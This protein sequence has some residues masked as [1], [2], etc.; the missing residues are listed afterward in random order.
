MEMHIYRQVMIAREE[1]LKALNEGTRSWT[2]MACINIVYDG[3]T[4]L[5][6]N[7]ACHAGLSH[8]GTGSH[9]VVSALMK[10]CNGKELLEEEA[11][12]FLEWLLNESPYSATFITKS[13]EEALYYKAIISSSFHDARLM[14][15]GQVAS[16]RLWEYEEV[17]RSFVDMAKAGVQKDL[18]FYLAHC[19]RGTFDRKG[20]TD[21]NHA[22]RGHVSLEP[23]I[24]GQDGLVNFLHHK[25]VDKKHNYHDNE[26]YRGYDYMYG[27]GSHIQGWIHKH[28]PYQGK[29]VEEKKANPFPM[30]D[31]G[32]GVK[33]TKSASYEDLIQGMVEFQHDI[34]KHIGFEG[35]V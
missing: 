9:A 32:G 10:P 19:I 35:K 24:M 16:R 20:N 34:F 8:G 18:A 2:Q 1:M 12:Y 3:K 11:L 7:Q 27:Q 31:K 13:A 14:A 25:L 28:F 23:S 15:A 22:G 17:A 29:K 6:T 33:A 30:D 26:S 5:S 21:W 4:H